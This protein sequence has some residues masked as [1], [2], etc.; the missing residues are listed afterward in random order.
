MD[1]HVPNVRSVCAWVAAAPLG[2][3]VVPEV[4]MRSE[5][6]PGS[7][8]GGP[9]RGHRGLDAVARRAGIRP[10]RP[11]ASPAARRCPRHAL[12]AQQDDAAEPSGVLP[13]QHGRVVGAQEAAHGDERR[14][15]GVADDVGRL[16][17]LE[18]RVQRHEHGTG[19]QEA[20]RGQHPLGAVGRPDGHPVPRPDAGRDEAAGVAVDLGRQLARRSGAAPRRPAPPAAPWRTAASSTRRGTVPQIRSARGSSW[21]G[22]APPIP[23][24]LTDADCSRR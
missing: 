21:S 11:P 14:H 3:P 1:D 17:A 15:A 5:T 10:A 12:V 8:L 2:W 19:P 18:A 22:G 7:D 4:K 9:G 20:E 23:T 6:S 24:P 16:A 13:R